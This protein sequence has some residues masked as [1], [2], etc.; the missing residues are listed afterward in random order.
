MTRPLVM[1][2]ILECFPLNQYWVGGTWCSETSPLPVYLVPTTKN[3][4]LLPHETL[5]VSVGK[6][7]SS[8]TH[9]IINR[10]LVPLSI[11]CHIRKKYSK[12]ITFFNRMILTFD[13]WPWPSN[14]SNMS[15][16]S[17]RVPNIMTECQTFSPD[18]VYAL[19]HTQIG[20]F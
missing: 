1:D 7:Y 3:L 17:I 14:S 6:K 18:S 19:T 2:A 10:V 9:Y 15:S 8:N 16:R 20:L 13:L 5:R 12:N 11:W 4:I